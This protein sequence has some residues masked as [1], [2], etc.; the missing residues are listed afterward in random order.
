MGPVSFM[1]YCILRLLILRSDPL[2]FI[3]PVTPL[4]APIRGL[5]EITRNRGIDKVRWY[6]RDSMGSSTSIKITKYLFNLKVYFS[7]NMVRSLVMNTKCSIF[8]LPNKLSLQFNYH[9]GI[10]PSVWHLTSL[11]AK[12]FLVHWLKRIS[13]ISHRHIRISK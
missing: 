9:K 12:K 10:G 6:I 3:G 13:K 11:Q 1:E 8:T 5:S 4:A 2:D 7:E